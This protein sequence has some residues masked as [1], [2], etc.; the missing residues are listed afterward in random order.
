MNKDQFNAL[1]IL[2][3]VEYIN[4][5]LESE[6]VTKV[7][8]SI[9]ID[10]ATVR[11]RFSRIGYKL[12]GGKY[13]ATENIPTTTM[14]KTTVATTNTSTAK[15]TKKATEQTQENKQI[16]V[17]ES[18]IESLEKQIESINNILNTITTETT[19]NITTKNNIKIKKYKGVEGVRSYRVNAKVLE[20]WK[21]FCKAHSEHKVGDLLANAMVEYMNKYK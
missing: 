14:K 1:E 21:V 20:Q 8:A 16:K 10:R 3:Q 11:K 18:K 6:S 9:G 5:G 15:V 7:C 12:E 13:I 17:L 2:E 19:N 4:K